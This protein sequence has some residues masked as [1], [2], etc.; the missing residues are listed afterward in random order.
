M[1]IGIFWWTSSD[2]LITSAR[3]SGITVD[4]SLFISFFNTDINDDDDDDDDSIDDAVL[5]TR[6]L[7][8]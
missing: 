2:E 1:D 5:L 7:A 3:D 6:W 8:L 4:W